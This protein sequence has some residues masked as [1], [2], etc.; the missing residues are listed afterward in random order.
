M[1]LKYP[2]CLKGNCLLLSKETPSQ[3][4]PLESFLGRARNPLHVE[5]L[6]KS[7]GQAT[8]VKKKK[9]TTGIHAIHGD[10]LISGHPSFIKPVPLSVCYS[11]W[12]SPMS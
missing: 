10:L 9:K 2:E 5:Q 4:P 1:V 11:E 12:N 6:R 7:Y 8:P 3:L